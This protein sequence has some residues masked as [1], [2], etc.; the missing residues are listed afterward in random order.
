MKEEEDIGHNNI[1]YG[2]E[3][4]TEKA[5]SGKETIQTGSIDVDLCV[6]GGYVGKETKKKE[7]SMP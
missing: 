6:T 3:Y 2:D 1:S 5:S 4:S 7:N